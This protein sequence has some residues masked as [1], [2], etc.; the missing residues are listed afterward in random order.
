M[1]SWIDFWNAEHSIYVNERHKQLH[2][3]NVALDFARHIP[4]PD[5]VVMDY[6][7]GEALYAEEIVQKCGRLILCEAAPKICAELA[8]RLGQLKK[9]EIL[10]PAGAAAMPDASVDLI[11]VNSVLQYLSKDQL[12]SLL[13]VWRAKL[14]SAG[15][16]VIADVIP[17]GVSPLRDASALL[18]F[19]A[20]GGFLLAALGGLVRTAMSDYGRIRKS[21]GFS[22]YREQEFVYLLARHGLTAS[23]VYPNFGHNQSRMTFSATR[24]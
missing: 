13:A 17:P 6:G 16:L 14:A 22:M 5:A 19:A 1:R 24:S 10:D 15:R 9:I 8:G 11:L 4:R 2:A 7:C 23:R 21:L 3:R 18:S 20:R 12:E